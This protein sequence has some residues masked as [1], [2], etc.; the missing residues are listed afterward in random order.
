MA[1]E[2]TYNKGLVG[3]GRAMSQNVFVDELMESIRSQV[4]TEAR[5]SSPFAS[6]RVLAKEPP[7]AAEQVYLKLCQREPEATPANSTPR[8]LPE[9]SGVRMDLEACITALEKF[10]DVNPRHPG[11]MNDRIQNVKGAMRRTLVWYTRPLRMFHT[12]VIRTLQQLLAVV[13]KQQAVMLDIA[14]QS[15]V[16]AVERRLEDVELGTCQIYEVA[17]AVAAASD[18]TAQQMEADFRSLQQSVRELQ[19]EVAALRQQVNRGGSGR[20]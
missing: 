8:E 11:F 9:L 3:Y 16:T 4:R 2:E 18:S 17:E 15:E 13:E 1:S 12:A 5:S 19:S 10:G 7:S 14:R 20:G 6:A